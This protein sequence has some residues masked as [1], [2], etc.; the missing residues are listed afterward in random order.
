MIFMIK[1]D[2]DVLL[3]LVFDVW[4]KKEMKCEWFVFEDDFDLKVYEL[5]FCVGGIEVMDGFEVNGICF[6]IEV[7]Y[8]D[9]VIC[10]CIIYVYCIVLNEELILV[11]LVMVEFFVVSVGIWVIYME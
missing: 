1:W 10:E 4:L 5:D 2:I 7:V 9:I 3:L 6:F 8:Y 11:L